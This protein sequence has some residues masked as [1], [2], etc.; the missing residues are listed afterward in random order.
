MSA[1]TDVWTGVHEERESLLAMLETLAPSEW[2]AQSLCAEWRI[3][4]V[5]GHLISET[6]MS[7]SKLVKGTVKNGFRVNRFIARD[8]CRKGD[9]N[10]DELVDTFRTVLT[11]CSHL[12][13]LSSM[14]MLEGIVVH[15]LDIRTPLNRD[16]A[17]PEDR[18]VLVASDLLSSRYFV[19]RKLFSELRVTATDVDWSSGAGAEVT[20]PI[21]GFVLAMSGRNVGLDQLHGEGMVTV[22]QRVGIAG[23]ESR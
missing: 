21:E 9:L 2:N 10:D 5:V 17:V 22:Q 1:A 12:P 16:Y 3:R 11:A 15:S 23:S 19:G 13:G 4:D 6:S 18:L 8:A 14:S 20:G 7:I